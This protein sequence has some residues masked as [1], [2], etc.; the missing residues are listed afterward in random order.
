M[1]QVYTIP[2]DYA[3]IH[4]YGKHYGWDA[5]QVKSTQNRAYS[6]NAP[7]DAVE[8]TRLGAVIRFRDLS[9]ELR[10]QIGGL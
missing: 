9:P 2:R 7:Y 1:E 4:A 10:Q 3:H 6:I 8:V 5:A